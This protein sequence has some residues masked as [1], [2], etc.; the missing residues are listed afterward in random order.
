MSCLMEAEMVFEELSRDYKLKFMSALLTDN[1]GEILKLRDQITELCFTIPD[2]GSR[3]IELS[4]VVKNIDEI[5]DISDP[6][7]QDAIKEIIEVLDDADPD[8]LYDEE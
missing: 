6:I 1:V 4:F 3:S 7:V 2:P 8:D 5:D